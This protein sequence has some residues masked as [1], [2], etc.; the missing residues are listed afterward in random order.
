ME[1]IKVRQTLK[2]EELIDKRHYYT[3]FL[4]GLDTNQKE[5]NLE[6]TEIKT[7]PREYNWRFTDAKGQ[8]VKLLP[9]ARSAFKEKAH[10]HYLAHIIEG[11]KILQ[12]AKQKPLITL[13]KWK[14]IE[15][16]QTTFINEAY[17][18]EM[19]FSK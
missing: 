8:E 2:I 1:E 4:A 5:L 9:Y 14:K 7:N 13:E 6:V 17:I 12:K 11:E 3:R 15:V 10:T 18:K 19:P 16:E